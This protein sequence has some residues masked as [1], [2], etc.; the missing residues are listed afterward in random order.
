M[1]YSSLIEYLLKKNR[2]SRYYKSFFNRFEEQRE[3]HAVYRFG[4]LQAEIIL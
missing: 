2:R 4:W 3:L 1:S